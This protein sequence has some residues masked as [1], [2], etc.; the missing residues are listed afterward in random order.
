MR[1]YFACAPLGSMSGAHIIRPLRPLKRHKRAL[2]GK[3]AL[4]VHVCVPN[5]HRTA[6]CCL[7]AC[8]VPLPHL[9]PPALP[10]RWPPYLLPALLACAPAACAAAL[11]ASI[12]LPEFAS[13]F[14]PSPFE[15]QDSPSRCWPQAPIFSGGIRHKKSLKAI[16]EGPDHRRGE[17]ACQRQRLMHSASQMFPLL[18]SAPHPRRSPLARCVR[19]QRVRPDKGD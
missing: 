12:I 8:P 6:L 9:L 11:P 13:F 5:T 1:R 10:P 19:P 17:K 18:F 7:P 3:S 15:A 2:A 16:T 4:D 14:P